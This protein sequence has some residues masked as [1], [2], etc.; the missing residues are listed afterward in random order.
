M[1]RLFLLLFLAFAYISSAQNIELR[2]TYQGENLYVQNPFAAS[3]VGF[4]VY[5]VTVNGMTT[6][7]EINSSA[8]EVDLAVFGFF[9]GEQITVVVKCKEGCSARVLNREVLNP[10]ATFEIVDIRVGGTN[11]N[12]TTIN[13]AGPLTFYVEQFRWNKWITIGEISGIG[14]PEKNSYT[15]PLRLHSGDNRF[16]IRQTDSRKTNKYSK[17]VTLKTRVTPVTFK[18]EGNSQIVFSAPTMYEIYDFYGRIVFK[19]FGDNVK[20][21]SLEKG[22]YYLNYDNKNDQFNKR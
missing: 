1:K 15:A 20:I 12:W 9:V 6:T 2:G 5:E 17:E 14:S 10:R 21:G 18:V 7:D 13:E 4:C 22:R 19:G 11:L 16:R 8:F 3:G